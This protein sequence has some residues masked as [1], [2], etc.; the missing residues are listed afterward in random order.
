MKRPMFD[1][2]AGAGSWP[3]W[4]TRAE[5][6]ASL[7]ALLRAEGIE[8]ACAYPLEGYLYADP[9]EANELRLPALCASEFFVP[10]A[11]LNPTFPNALKRY[12]VCRGEWDVPMVR[13]TPNYHDY[14]LRDPGV[15]ALAERMSDDG[16]ILGIHLRMQDERSHPSILK[17]P[18]VPF[19]DAVDLA[20]RYPRLNVVVLGLAF[21]REV[22][23]ANILPEGFVGTIFNTPELEH[24]A[25]APENLFVELSFFEWEDSFESALKIFRPSQLL[26]G[27]H[28]PVFY[29]RST[30]FKIERSQAP[31]AMKQAA[32]SANAE[33]LFQSARK[34]GRS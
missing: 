7:E 12:E 30:I 18:A 25:E 2:N 5:D 13:L 8:R 24:R 17:V 29:P 33:G 21:A 1:I 4:R 31:E 16:V 32:F 3:F 15:D 10:S 11:M 27:S 6:P 22:Q 14:T 26:F 28:A 20:W 34:K 9:M 23:Q 19:A